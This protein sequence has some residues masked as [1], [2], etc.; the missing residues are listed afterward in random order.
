[1]PAQAPQQ[2][3]TQK[4]GRAMKFFMYQD[5]RGDWRW[6]LVAANGK[7]VADSAEGY[8]GQGNVRR[9]IKAF[10][11]GIDAAELVV[12]KEHKWVWPTG[13]DAEESSDGNG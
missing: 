3:H 2:T 7:T 1:M 6:R 12:V 13:E 9:A 8:N 5:K 10:R 11:K 4:R